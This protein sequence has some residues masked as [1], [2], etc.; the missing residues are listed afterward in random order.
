M[1]LGWLR[2]DRERSLLQQLADTGPERVG[3]RRWWGGDARGISA[4]PR[5][6]LWEIRR[7]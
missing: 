7:R 1:E 6:D 3:Y 4:E 5:G 2:F